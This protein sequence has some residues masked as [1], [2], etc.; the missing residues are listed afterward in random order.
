MGL[1]THGQKTFKILTVKKPFKML[2]YLNDQTVK[3]RFND[4]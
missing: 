4:L 3:A 2:M 1:M